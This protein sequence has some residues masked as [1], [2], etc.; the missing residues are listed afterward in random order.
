MFRILNETGRVYGDRSGVALE[1]PRL[2]AHVLEQLPEA[3]FTDSDLE[4]IPLLTDQ[5]R[6]ELFGTGQQQSSTF[7]APTP[8]PAADIDE[9]LSPINL[10]LDEWSCSS[11]TTRSMQHYDGSPNDRRFSRHLG[12]V[13]GRNRAENL[14]AAWQIAKSLMLVPSP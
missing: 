13:T 5:E 10:H 7:S 4:A 1:E 8:P 2:V 14:A 12:E 6:C 9:W 11:D 3:G